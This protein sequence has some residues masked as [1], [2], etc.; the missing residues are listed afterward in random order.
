VEAG[1]GAVNLVHHFLS[2]GCEERWPIV[3][4]IARVADEPARRGVPVDSVDLVG[5]SEVLDAPS[6]VERDLA[7]HRPAQ[8]LVALAEEHGVAVLAEADDADFAFRRGALRK[9]EAA[10]RL[11]LPTAP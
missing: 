5:R 11:E 3:L 10:G 9:H 2:F 8:L 1:K 7:P 6:P 4:G